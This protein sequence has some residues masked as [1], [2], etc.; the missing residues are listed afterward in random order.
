M[1][2]ITIWDVKKSGLDVDISAQIADVETCIKT[3]QTAE[4][5]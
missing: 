3:L 4:R 1:S 5:R 2:L